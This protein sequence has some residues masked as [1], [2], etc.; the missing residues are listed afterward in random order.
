MITKIIKGG[1]R[2]NI[3]FNVSSHSPKRSDFNILT[4]SNE[5]EWEPGRGGRVFQS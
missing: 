1:Q 5:R 4:E 3:H 2:Q